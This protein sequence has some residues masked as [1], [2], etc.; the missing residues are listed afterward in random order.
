MELSSNCAVF[1]PEISGI[2]PDTILRIHGYK[3]PDK[4][5]PVIRDT[6]KTMLTTGMSLFEPVI[7]YREVQIQSLDGP[8]LH[9][10]GNAVTFRNPDFDALLSG[11]SHIVV[12][13]LTLGYAPDKK[14][15]E[16]VSTDDLLEAVFLETA[17]WLGIERATRCFADEVRAT[18][19]INNCRITRRL[20]PG[21]K[22][23]AL[24]DQKHLFALFEGTDMEITLLDG[25]CMQPKMSRS[26]I[27]GIAPK[28]KN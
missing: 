4:V 9:L 24:T 15:T 22:D 3:E 17:C 23:W 14:S 19:E 12:F 11:C 6:A 20:A 1:R 10:N 2:D 5:K 13:L 26:G 21:Y 18:A 27:Y 16:L 28:V 7:Y 8:D 25:D